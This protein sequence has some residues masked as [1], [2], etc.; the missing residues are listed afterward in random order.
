[1]EEVVFL[2]LKELGKPRTEARRSRDMAVEDAAYMLLIPAKR[3]RDGAHADAVNGQHALGWLRANG[4]HEAPPSRARRGTG[5]RL[6][7]PTDLV[8]T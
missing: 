1:M 2:H 4:C 6:C 3:V 7:L 5:E 8:Q